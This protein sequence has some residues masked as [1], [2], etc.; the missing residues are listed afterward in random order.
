MSKMYIYLNQTLRLFICIKFVTQFYVDLLSLFLLLLYT[1]NY[2]FIL[3]Y[4]K[5]V[6]THMDCILSYLQ[7][8]ISIHRHR[9]NLTP[10][11]LNKFAF[12]THKHIETLPLRVILL[13]FTNYNKYYNSTHINTFLLIFKY[14]YCT[15]T[16]NKRDYSFIIV[17][18]IQSL[19]CL[20]KRRRVHLIQLNN[21][22]NLT[23]FI[24]YPF[25]YLSNILIIKR[26]LLYKMIIIKH[27]NLKKYNRQ[28]YI[29][30][31]TTLFIIQLEKH[32]TICYQTLAINWKQEY[33]SIFTSSCRR[34]WQMVVS[35]EHHLLFT[36]IFIPYVTHVSSHYINHSYDRTSVYNKQPNNFISNST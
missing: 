13:F 34:D 2:K 1:L 8:F 17:I 25:L 20:R 21:I 35:T 4:L 18:Q 9:Y 6:N 22:I 3:K 11:Q 33:L 30:F 10:F 16:I 15:C 14:T 32:K 31:K 23:L 7:H 24:S 28:R 27:K 26:I 5:N 19:F 29:F 36:P 12:Y